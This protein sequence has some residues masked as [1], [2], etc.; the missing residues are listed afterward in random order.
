MT[1][2]NF[3]VDFSIRDE[4]GGSVMWHARADT[5]AE[6]ALHVAELVAQQPQLRGFVNTRGAQTEPRG[7]QHGSGHGPDKQ[8]PAAPVCPEHG[9]AKPSSF[10]GVYC[11][12]R[13]DDDSFCR[14][15]FGK[16]AGKNA[17]AA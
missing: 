8:D 4:A 17:R 1:E 13:L 16:P 10:G 11:T 12:A 2:H 5:A 15:T 3:A 7:V 6:F 14:W 9:Q